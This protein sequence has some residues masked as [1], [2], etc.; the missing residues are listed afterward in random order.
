M[1]KFLQ[2]ILQ[3]II[4]PKNGWCD[5]AKSNCDQKLL[6]T[7]GFYPLLGLASLSSFAGVFF[8]VDMTL[9]RALQDAIVIFISYFITYFLAELLFSTF[10]GPL[11][12]YS[13]GG[14]VDDETASVRY[15]SDN[16][17]YCTFI[18]YNLSILVLI[19]LIRNLLPVELSLIQFLPFCVAFI[20]WKGTEYMSIPE[21]KTG[22]FMFLSVFS[23][24]MPTYIFQYLFQLII[25]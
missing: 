18:I 20:M 23:I 8:D 22:Q 3:L 1:L 10:L 13:G 19:T 16:R 15:V 25:G 14:G 9:V 11:M 6:M 7:T 17:L 24:L 21:K 2:Y 5:I 12:N 4:S